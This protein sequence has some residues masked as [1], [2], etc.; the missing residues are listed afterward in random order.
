MFT[1]SLIYASHGE[2]YDEIE[3]KY[4]SYSQINF[5]TILTGQIEMNKHICDKET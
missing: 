3:E 4:N 2:S 1:G 5:L